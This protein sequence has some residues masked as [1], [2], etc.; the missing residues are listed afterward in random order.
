MSKSYAKRFA[1]WLLDVACMSISYV[2]AIN[3]RFDEP[4]SGDVASSNRAVYAAMLIMTL[5]LNFAMHDNR[6]FMRRSGVREFGHAVRYSLLLVLGVAV[7]S[8][9]FKIEPSPSRLMLLA[10]FIIDIVAMCVGRWA[11]KRAARAVFR[12]ERVGSAIVMIVGKGQRRYVE[13]NFVP[14]MTYTIAGWLVMS[15]GRV[16]GD[17]REHHISCE[18]VEL[19]DAFHA[20]GIEHIPD[21]YVCAPQESEHNIAEVVDAAERLGASCHVAIDVPYP[22]IQGASLG[23]FGEL[24]VVTYSTGGSD[25]YRRYIKRVLDFVFSLLVVV[26]LCWLYLIVAIAVKIDDPEGPVFFKQRRIGKDGRPFTMW[27]FRSMYAD[28]E[29]RLVELQKYNEKDGPVFKIKDDPRITRVGHFIRKTSLDEMPQ[30]FNVLKGDMSIVGPRPALPRE[31]V[32]YTPHQR[33]RLLVRPGLTCYWQVQPNRDDISFDEWVDLD[34]LYIRQCSLA[35]DAKLVVDT[36]G[37]VFTGQ[38]N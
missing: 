6:G 16:E 34:L 15:G 11:A 27:K 2:V 17:V 24:P 4:V 20:V 32:Q 23:F 38:G 3:L 12:D 26:L 9:V 29:K 28:A 19:P 33:E 36:V 37:V 21:F 31:V 10:I 7:V 25:L 22:G 8:Y 14:G 30:F 1:L 35:V 18:V 5:V 13:K